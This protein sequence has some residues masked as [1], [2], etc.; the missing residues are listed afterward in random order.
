MAFYNLLLYPQGASHTSL[1]L[2]CY[3]F[4]ILKMDFISLFF[5]ANLQNTKF[6]LDNQI[7]SE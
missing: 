1:P 5:N 3:I 6:I 7:T 2:L 4:R